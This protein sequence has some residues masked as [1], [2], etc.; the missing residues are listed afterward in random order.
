M[1][2][3]TPFLKSRGSILSIVLVLVLLLGVSGGRTANAQGVTIRFWMQ[4]DNL[5]QAAMTDL[6]NAFQADNPTIKVQLEAFP[7]AEYHQKVSTAFAGGD[8]PDVF[9]MDVR[10]ASFAQQG[11]LMALDDY[12]TKENRDDYLDATWKEPT[13]Q[14]KTYGVPMHELT[15]ALYVNTAMASAAGIKLPKTLDEAWTWDQF[16]DAA[17]KLTQR[18][19]DK[20]TVWGFG[21][22]R[23]LQDWSVLP[24]VYQHGG[25]GPPDDPKTPSGF[26]NRTPNL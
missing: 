16:L 1:M 18:S 7:F 17:K 12:I 3:T 6:V 24:I 4:Q 21:V 19:G 10:T 20:T 14:G 2:R 15:E 13:Y 25:K 9:W 22:Q 11:V 23:Q 26:L 8:A 5:L